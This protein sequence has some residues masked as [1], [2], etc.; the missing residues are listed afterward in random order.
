PPNPFRSLRAGDRSACGVSV[1]GAI[2]GEINAGAPSQ[3]VGLGY[4]IFSTTNT[5][6]TSY[7]FAVI[8]CSALLG[9]AI[10]S[11]VNLIGATVLSRWQT[12]TSDASNHSDS[13]S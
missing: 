4:L 9:V 5:M 13:R 6:D 12:T 2:V 10:F 11:A 7:M 8:I 3:A 1:V